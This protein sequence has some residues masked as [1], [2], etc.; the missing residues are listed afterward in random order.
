MSRKVDAKTKAEIIELSKQHTPVN[1]AKVLRLHPSTV[2]K[3]LREDMEGKIVASRAF[4]EH[5][6]EMSEALR[7]LVS[8]FRVAQTISEE[9]GE[10]INEVIKL[11]MSR[12]FLIEIEAEMVKYEATP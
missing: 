11:I 9:T 6:D 12:D 2:R 4:Q 7:K 8:I 5:C 1:I 10:P 3:Y